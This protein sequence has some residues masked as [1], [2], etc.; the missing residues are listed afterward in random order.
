VRLFHLCLYGVLLSIKLSHMDS[1]QPAKRVRLIADPGRIGVTTEKVR[2]RGAICMVQVVYPDSTEYIPVDQLEE[3]ESETNPID[4]LEKGRLGYVGDLRRNLTYI[5]LSGRLANVIYSMQTTHTDFYP[6][7][8]KP[9]LK[10]LESP[11][12]GILIADEVGLGKTIEAG[13]IWTELRSRIDARRLLILCPAMLQEKWYLELEQR[14]GVKATI[15]NA[16]DALRTLKSIESQGSY[17]EFAL[18]CSMQGLRPH[19]EWNNDGEAQAQDPASELARYLDDKAYESPLVDLLV[20]DEAHYLRNPETLTS[21]L[22]H[23]LRNVAEYVALLSATPIHLKNQDLYELL[24]LVDEDTFNRVDDFDYLLEAN[25]PL[26]KLREAV[27]KEDVTPSELLSLLEA[28]REN[29]FLR[30]SRQIQTILQDPPTA[31]A[32]KDRSTKSLLAHRFESLNVWN[33][34]YTRTRK[35]E[36]SEGRVIREPV[37]EEVTLSEVEYQFYNDVTNVVREY[38]IREDLPTGFLYTTPQ[39]QMASSMPAALRSWRDRGKVDTQVLYEGLGVVEEE[40]RAPLIEEIVGHLHKLVDLDSLWQNDSKFKR[41]AKMLRSYL[42]EH[43]SE[44]IVLFAYFRATLDYLHE[45]LSDQGISSIVLKGGV[46]KQEV[47]KQFSEPEGPSVLLSSEVG[48]EGIDLQFARLLINYD[49]PWNPM[50]I[51]QRIGRLDR[52]GQKSPKITIW[53]L[54]A[55][56]TIEARIYERLYSRLHLFERALGG[57]EG[58]LGEEVKKLS[59]DLMGEKLTPGQEAARIDQAAQA[60]ENLRQ[61]EERLEQEATGLIA[62]GDYILNEVHAA[63][64]LNRWIS[65]QDLEKYVHD[66]FAEHYTGTSFKLLKQ[67]QLVYDVRLSIQ[68]KHDLERFLREYR[69]SHLTRLAQSD[70]GPIRCRF[71]N[72]VSSSLVGQEEIISQFHPLVRFVSH[73]IRDLEVSYHPVVGV[74]L[75]SAQVPGLKRATY[76]FAVQRWVIEGIQDLER[77]HFVAT[78]IDSAGQYLDEEDAEKLITSAS[79]HGEDWLD[80]NRVVDLGLAADMANECFG[81]ADRKYQVYV[82]QLRDEN[83]DRANVQEQSLNRHLKNQKNKLE[84]IKIRHQSLN[85]PQL[86][87]MTEGRIRALEDRVERRRL[88]INT[89][90]EINIRKEEVGAGIIEVEKE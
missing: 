39:M 64:E 49:L 72:R 77:L 20:I 2:N 90:R 1:M 17:A 41:L 55:G 84:E 66:F 86:V 80:A 70:R 81:V 71:E 29:E 7:Q 22:G 3:V 82:Q 61:E 75:N 13:L 76:V 74:K 63:R 53:N 9:V 37:A 14:F 73:R 52:I 43:P 85:R 33:H 16:R 27:V 34:V 42:K 36:V 54:Y 67:N 79:V 51:E 25:V 48:S 59:M 30:N 6:Y 56:N 18:I 46:D 89:R 19:R 21:K 10:I 8:Y 12:N 68:A 23:L 35:R 87:N 45:R 4:L 83:S 32:L 40:D 47:I 57:M 24:H 88:D 62:H 69:L 5:R 60:I 31:E 11:T 26:V 28:A 65:S 78:S 44:K 50:R 38:C 58:M 15:A